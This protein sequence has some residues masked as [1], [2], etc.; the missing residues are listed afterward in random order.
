METTWS[1]LTKLDK[2]Y[3]STDRPVEKNFQTIMQGVANEFE[4]IV[5]FETPKRTIVLIGEQ[6]GSILRKTFLDNVSLLSDPLVLLEAPVINFVDLNDD[7]D[8]DMDEMHKEFVR[9]HLK[10]E[11]IDI[12][13]EY[14]GRVTHPSSDEA[15]YLFESKTFRAHILEQIDYTLATL[16]HVLQCDNIDM[17]RS[18]SFYNS[19]VFP[20]RMQCKW[21]HNIPRKLLATTKPL[22]AL[23][24]QGS[25]VEKLKRLSNTPT[26]ATDDFLRAVAGSNEDALNAAFSKEERLEFADFKR[27]A[28]YCQ[29]KICSWYMLAVTLS[30]IAVEG[31][32][33]FDTLVVYAGSNHIGDIASAVESAAM[34]TDRKPPVISGSLPVR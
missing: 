22:D 27:A 32:E 20:A 14:L 17:S 34:G 7:D 23:L 9:S 18:W 5:V 6:H 31:K 26:P 11:P 4:Q 16:Q 3:R 33:R 15:D 28:H 12:R 13:P 1:A 25:V 10:V 29:R 2:L 19:D 21:A 8:D 30:K 24:V